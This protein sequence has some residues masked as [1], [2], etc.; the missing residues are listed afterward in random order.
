MLVGNNISIQM[1][2]F[3]CSLPTSHYI[4]IKVSVFCKRCTLNKQTKKPPTPYVLHDWPAL[5]MGW[6][7]HR[8]RRELFIP[9]QLSMILSGSLQG[10]GTCRYCTVLINQRLISRTV[11]TQDDMKTSN[12]GEKIITWKVTDECN[13][14]GNVFLC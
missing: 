3:C 13:V 12:E 4:Q 2:A 6:Q 11:T 10:F 7:K 14:K 9:E 5:L 8:F 1:P